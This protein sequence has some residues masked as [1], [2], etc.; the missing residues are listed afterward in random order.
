VG[1]FRWVFWV[2]FW[3][4]FFGWV[5]Y[6]QPWLWAQQGQRQ[7]QGWA[8]YRGGKSAIV[9]SQQQQR[10]KQQQGTSNNRNSIQGANR[11]TAEQTRAAETTGILRT[12]IGQVTPA[13]AG[14]SAQAGISATLLAKKGRKQKDQQE[15][16]RQQE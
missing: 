14:L 3:V 6:C 12:K 7:Q 15:Q 2:V 9:R 10:H 16:G 5:F 1:F 13:I 4:G 8:Q 11:I